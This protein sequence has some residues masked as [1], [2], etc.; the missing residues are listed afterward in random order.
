MITRRQLLGAA[1]MV[2]PG[3]GLI[4]SVA[5]AAYPERPIRLVV[6]YAPGGGSDVLARLVANA[7]SRRLSKSIV[8][9]NKG[10]A[11]GALG[12]EYV[13]RAP[14]DGYTLILLSTSHAS[15][16]AVMSLTY[17]VI[18]DVTP[19][20]LIASGPWILVVNSNLHV[21]DVTELLA[22]AKAKPDSLN[23]ASSGTGSSTHLATA[24]FAQKAGIK[25]TH[26]PYR[27]SGQALTDLIAGRVQ[28]MLASAPSVTGYVRD[29]KLKALCV[30]TAKRS[31]LF[32]DLPTAEQAGIH[33]FAEALWHG[34]A[35][36]AKI[37]EKIVTALNQSLVSSLAEPS[38][39][40]Q[41]E[42]QGLEPQASTPQEFSTMLA[43]DVALWR[44]I[45]KSID[46]S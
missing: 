26:V 20:G 15:N 12:L 31:P 28:F 29:G 1:S 40:K 25:V 21:S 22:L 16:A 41:F 42:T 18:K 4:H 43:N 35:A 11:G 3:A 8:V 24:L 9:E 13:V 7:M 36:P 19:I 27:S 34:L 37:P 46:I 33:G 23:Y 38:L 5:H 17:D 10:G 44:A 30:S 45:A 39:R 32:P 14:A 6:P 2:L